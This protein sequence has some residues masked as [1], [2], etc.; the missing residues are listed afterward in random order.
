MVL[1]R[2]KVVKFDTKMYLNFSNFRGPTSAGADKPWSKNGDKC[3]MG[4]IGKIFTRWGTPSPPRKKPCFFAKFGIAIGRFSSETK[5]P[6]FKNWVYF[7]QMIVQST[8][9]RQNWVLFYPIRYTDGWVIGR[10]IGIEK[11]K[12]SRFETSTYDFGESTP[13]PGLPPQISC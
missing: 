3:W 9:F 7:E 12:F 4:E 13:P 8:Q 10:K 5:E 6:K 2:L 11:V 1:L